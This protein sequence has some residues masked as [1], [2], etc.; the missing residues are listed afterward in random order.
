M[1]KPLKP[2]PKPTPKKGFLIKDGVVYPYTKENY[3]LLK[4]KPNNQLK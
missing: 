1:D 3:E 2:R 4:D